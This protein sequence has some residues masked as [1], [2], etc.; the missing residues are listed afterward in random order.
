[1]NGITYTPVCWYNNQTVTSSASAVMIGG[2][3][4]GNNLIWSSSET[5]LYYPD[6]VVNSVYAYTADEAQLETGLARVAFPVLPVP[7]MPIPLPPPPPPPPAHLRAERLLFDH[8]SSEQRAQYACHKYFD[9]EVGGRRYR[10]HQG[11][12]GNIKRLN[13]SDR[14]IESLCVHFPRYLPVPDLMLA[15][16]LALETDELALRNTAN[17]TM[18]HPIPERRVA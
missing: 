1:M 4:T 7:A 18:M 15:Q 16:K 14:A 10:I 3:S 8:L 11:W 17:I 6:T 2:W 5:V 9:V 13:E 12:S